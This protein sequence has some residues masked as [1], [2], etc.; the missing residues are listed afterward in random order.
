[1]P[2]TPTQ[3]YVFF[4]SLIDVDVVKVDTNINMTFNQAIESKNSMT[5]TTIL[6]ND[7]NAILDAQYFSPDGPIAG[8]NYTVYR[9]TPNQTYYDFICIMYFKCFA[10]FKY[11][12]FITCYNDCMWFYGL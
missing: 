5:A 6:F 11:F 1:M 4:N 10:S 7:F 9:R 12:L 8:A 3:S 2:E